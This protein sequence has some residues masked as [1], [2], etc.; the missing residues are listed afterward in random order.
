[1][2]D[3]DAIEMA[4]RKV[5]AL[6]G[7]ARRALDICRRAV[8]IAQEEK[9]GT[10]VGLKHVT[11]AVEEMSSSPM[12]MA[13]RLGTTLFIVTYSKKLSFFLSCPVHS[14]SVS[15]S[16][17]LSLSC[18]LLFSYFLFQELFFQSKVVFESAHHRT[19]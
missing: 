10:K 11:A 8:E 16:R 17:S 15:L 14:L 3:P 12:V 7:D 19:E 18:A 6:S 9:K 2:F 13:I 1:M 4:G 5:A